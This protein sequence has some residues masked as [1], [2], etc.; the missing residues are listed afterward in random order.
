MHSRV[1]VLKWQMQKLR[2]DFHF[3]CSKET[4]A[5]KDRDVT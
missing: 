3:G 4:N 1:A 2:V 5:R